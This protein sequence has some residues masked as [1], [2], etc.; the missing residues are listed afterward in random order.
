MSTIQQQTRVS[1][2]AEQMFD[3]V[4]NVSHYPEFVPYCKAA[5]V[6]VASATQMIAT[7]VLAKKGF[8]QA[9]TTVNQLSY[10]HQIDMRLHEGPFRHLMGKWAFVTPATGG[11][12]SVQ[13]HLDFEFKNSLLHLTMRPVFE[14]IMIDMVRAFIQRAH[15]VYT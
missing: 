7:L 14:K 3:L 4:N 9:F 5:K 13:F 10:P 2:S 15:Q 8:S 1:F 11:G 12:C 6:K